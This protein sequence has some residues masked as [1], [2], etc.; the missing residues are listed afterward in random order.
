MLMGRKGVESE[1]GKEKTQEDVGKGGK[2]RGE[3]RRNERKGGK[4][5]GRGGERRRILES[6]FS[7][8]GPAF[9]TWPR[10]W[11]PHG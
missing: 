6:A 11:R 2:E 3:D 9:S 5:E 8:L 4:E 1:A 7:K 10:C